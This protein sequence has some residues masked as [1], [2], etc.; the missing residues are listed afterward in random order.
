MYLAFACL[1]F[2]VSFAQKATDMS[3]VKVSPDGTINHSV[4]DKAPQLKG[5]EASN[6][7]SQCT[8]DKI[9]AFVMNDLMKNSSVVSSIRKEKIKKVYVRFVVTPQGVVQNVGVR[10]QNAQLKSAIQQIIE[11]LPT[12]SP[13]KQKG[14]AVNAAYSLNIDLSEV[15]VNKSSQTK[16]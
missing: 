3:V 4:L 8:D 10:T 5:C 13:G 9:N 15:F 12:F 1:F 6:N 7:A 16:L 14:R 11:K 2:Q